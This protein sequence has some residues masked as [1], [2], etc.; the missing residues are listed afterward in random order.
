MFIERKKEL[1]KLNT[2]YDSGKFQLTILYGKRNTGKTTLIKEFC[3]NK[4]VI[5]LAG[6]CADESV[7]LRHFCHEIETRCKNIIFNNET[8]NYSL[9][10]NNWEDIFN[11]IYQLSKSQ[12]IVFVMDEY[13]YLTETGTHFSIQLNDF[14][15]NKFSSSQVFLIL[16]SSSIDY[17]KDK[18]VKSDEYLYQKYHALLHIH[19]FHYFEM[20]FLFPEYTPEEQLLLYGITNGMP[21]YLS[22]IDANLSVRNNIINLYLTEN[23]ILYQ[24]VF[25]FMNAVFREPSTYNSII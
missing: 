2:L 9:N 19:P 10:L 1:K 14:I 4:K 20:K 22:N 15:K 3:K 7:Q 23:G 24:E 18:L 8:F 6:K 21:G 13:Q 12:R 25:H 17:I 5:Y 11:C 16:C